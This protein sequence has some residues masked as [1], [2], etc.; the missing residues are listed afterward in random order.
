MDLRIQISRDQVLGAN[1]NEVDLSPGGGDGRMAVIQKMESG[2]GAKRC[3]Q[4]YAIEAMRS[5]IAPILGV[6]LIAVISK[7]ALIAMLKRLRQRLGSRTSLQRAVSSVVPL[8]A[9]LAVT[10]EGGQVPVGRAKAIQ[11]RGLQNVGAG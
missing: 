3:Y 4:R 1:R 9:C 10:K 7:I 2:S 11:E 6:A 5:Q 8:E